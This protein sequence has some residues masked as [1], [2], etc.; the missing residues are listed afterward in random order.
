MHS[1][2]VQYFG[3][4]SDDL[5]VFIFVDSCHITVMTFSE[6]DKMPLSH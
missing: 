4:V 6:A 1:L 5:N 2:I 3:C